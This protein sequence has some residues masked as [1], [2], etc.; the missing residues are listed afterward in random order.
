[1]K[2]FLVKYFPPEKTAKIIK[3]ITTFQQFDMESLCDAWERFKELQRSYPH[4]RLPK[5]HT[6][7]N[8]VTQSTRDTID[9]ATEGFLMR[10]TVDA[11]FGLLKE[12]ANNKCLW[13][14]KC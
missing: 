6:F 7:Y 2:A 11:A 4:Y 13:P 10:K 5:I 1:M 14:S 8:C 3:D 12:M 9:A